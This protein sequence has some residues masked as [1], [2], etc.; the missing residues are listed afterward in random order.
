MNIHIAAIKRLF[1]G[2]LTVSVLVGGG[3]YWFG[4]WQMSQQVVELA[5]T[6]VSRGAS[7]ILRRVNGNPADIL[8]L[9]AKAQDYQTQGFVVVE[10]YNRTGQMVV[11]RSSPQATPIERALDAL[12]P[13]HLPRGRGIQTERMT[14][15]NNE[16]IRVLVPLLNDRTVEGHFEGIYIVPEDKV[17]ALRAETRR[18]LVAVFVVVLFTTLLLYPFILSL[19]RKVHAEA[20]A[21]LHSNIELMEV[22]GSAIAKRDSDTNWH[23]YRVT[24]SAVR[25]AQAIGLHKNQMKELI[26][27]AFLHD[28]G[29]IGI[30]D[31]ILLKPGKLDE[32]EFSVMKQHVTLGLEIISHSAWLHH[33]RDVVGCHHEWF[34]GTGYPKGLAGSRI[35]LTA[36]IFAI[37]DVFDALTSR[38]PYKEPLPLQ[39]SLDMLRQGEGTHFDP[40]LL[41]VFMQIAPALHS[42]F[43]QGND[44]ELMHE[45]H[46]LVEFYWN[47]Q[48][49]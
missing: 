41:D 27:G 47:G 14:L 28:V 23:N 25:L 11:Q 5:K 49:A 42:R 13:H 34:D 12:G 32:A 6:E 17:Q 46:E 19:N 7:E 26:S 8:A 21:I 22:L 20:H 39:T 38:R 48:S 1:L 15:D 2:W 33:A 18:L 40:A 4:L 43:K 10:M 3:A 31:A 16:V 44:H 45:M 29:K 9:Q 24:I 35:P 30:H 37:V 36:R